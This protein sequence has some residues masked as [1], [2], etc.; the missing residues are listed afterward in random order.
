MY[1]TCDTCMNVTWANSGL[2][3]GI[4]DA[5]KL[6]IAASR[7]RWRPTHWTSLKNK[8]HKVLNLPRRMKKNS[9]IWVI[10]WKNGILKTG[11]DLLKT[12]IKMIAKALS[13]SAL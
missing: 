9:N 6:A 3:V 10:W 7:Q 4:L 5:L 2:P 12:R 1:A 8:E 11:E 13:A